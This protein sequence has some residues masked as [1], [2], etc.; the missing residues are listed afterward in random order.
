MC[1]PASTA[2][3]VWE[4]RSAAR[5]KDAPPRRP[6]ARNSKRGNNW[7]LYE[8][9][10]DRSQ[11]SKLMQDLS[12]TS[13]TLHHVLDLE[14]SLRPPDR[15]NSSPC[16][17][18]SD[19]WRFPQARRK[20]PTRQQSTLQRKL[21]LP[22]EKQEL[23]SIGSQVWLEEMSALDDNVWRPGLAVS[24]AA[25]GLYPTSDELQQIIK[26]CP[27]SPPS[28]FGQLAAVSPSGRSSPTPPRRI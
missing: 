26:V 10:S 23:P 25:L 21:A 2:L 1:A 16:A 13:P 14:S 19:D 3:R 6:P 12:S 4:L 15:S 11:A 5:L 17:G 28:A 7:R 24:P 8:R 27:D 22:I 20:S 18:M 9:G